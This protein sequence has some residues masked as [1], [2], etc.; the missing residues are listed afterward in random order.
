M[1]L[2]GL[3]VGGGVRYAGKRWNDAENTRAE[4][5]YTLA[6][7]GICYRLQG[8]ELG[9]NFDNLFDKYYVNSR[10]FAGDYVGNK[11]MVRLAIR[12]TL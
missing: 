4:K 8:W 5:A 10:A 7:A 2:V 9:A 1:G 11:R 6:D 3:S 12:G